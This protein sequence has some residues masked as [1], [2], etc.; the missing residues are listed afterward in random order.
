MAFPLYLF[1]K[2]D[3]FLELKKVNDVQ[4]ILEIKVYWCR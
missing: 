2:I 4:M 3:K 1:S